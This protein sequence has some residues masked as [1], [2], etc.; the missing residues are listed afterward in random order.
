VID[1][2]VS[3][4]KKCQDKSFIPMD[5]WIFFGISIFLTLIFIL[6]PTSSKRNQTEGSSSSESKSTIPQLKKDNSSGTDQ[7]RAMIQPVKEHQSRA[8]RPLL[9]TL[10]SVGS[11]QLSGNPNLSLSVYPVVEKKN[12]SDIGMALYLYF[13]SSYVTT[14][15]TIY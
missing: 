10:P 12:L 1:E 8:D 13:T 15:V 7:Q 6:L 3:L 4:L 11:T 9:F 14:V 5:D 2:A